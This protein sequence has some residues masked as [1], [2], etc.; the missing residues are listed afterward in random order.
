MISQRLLT[1]ACL[2][3]MLACT[4]SQHLTT[5]NPRH[6]EQI[7]KDI[8]Y[9]ASDALEGR[10][11][12]SKGGQLAA[13]YISE[14]MAALKL[15]P[16][17][18][19][20]GWFQEFAIPQ[21]D[22]HNPHVTT[23]V[24]QGSNVIGYLDHGAPSTVVIGAHYDHLGMGGFGSLSFSGPA[25]HNGA[26][27]NA[28]GV[29]GL[30]YLAE[31][32]KKR[33]RENNFLFIAFAGEERGLLGSNYFVKHPTVDLETVNYMLNMD[34]IGRLKQDKTLAVNGVGTS[35]QW[36]S[37][38]ESMNLEGLKLVKSASG[39]GPSDHTSFYYEGVPVLH[40]FTGQHEDYHKPSDDVERI[41]FD[42][43]ETVARYIANIIGSLDD[44]GRLEFQET[45]DSTQT[46]R[47]DFKV[48]LGVMPDYLF[49]GEGMRIDG[50]RPD[51]PAANAGMVKGDIV[52]QMGEVK[53]MNMMSYMEA[54][55]EFSPGDTVVIIIERDGE[56]IEKTVTFD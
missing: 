27:D 51:R 6:S 18:D 37:S 3:T 38:L 47:S 9:L 11:S 10:E 40:F 16:M 55:G 41:N 22:P 21:L 50:V 56:R 8:T 20:G 23:S 14:R 31:V 45:Q 25:I 15:T 43:L 44:D 19:Q 39:V 52:L 36:E 46:V 34:M 2:L 12:G 29:A 48:T 42:G 53:V 17:G 35:P 7:K 54:L 26:D 28:S 49:T 24:V 5:T 33:F 13:E 4:G 30:L 32:C 1:G